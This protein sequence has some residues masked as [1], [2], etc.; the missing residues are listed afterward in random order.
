MYKR[1]EPFT[2]QIDLK[3]AGVVRAKL[4]SGRRT[5]VVRVSGGR[6]GRWAGGGDRP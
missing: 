5:C 3:R 1:F 6:Q 2:G 4:V